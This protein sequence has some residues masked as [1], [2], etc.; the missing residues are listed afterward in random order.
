MAL[1]YAGMASLMLLVLYF[2]MS[3]L[4]YLLVGFFT[5]GGI[6]SMH[7]AF[8]ALLRRPLAAVS[9]CAPLRKTVR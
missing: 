8:S 3:V 5:L 9:A 1:G 2:F 7:A 6:V 4:F